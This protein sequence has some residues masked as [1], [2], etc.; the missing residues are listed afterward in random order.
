MPTISEWFC[1]SNYNT[2]SKYMYTNSMTKLESETK[3]N[4]NNKIPWVYYSKLKEESKPQYTFYYK[5]K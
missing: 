3:I 1:C 2:N 5:W 4:N